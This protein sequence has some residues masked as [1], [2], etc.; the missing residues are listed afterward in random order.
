MEHGANMDGLTLEEVLS[1]LPVDD[2]VRNYW[3]QEPLYIRGTREKLSKLYSLDRFRASFHRPWP[4]SAHAKAVFDGR[5]GEGSDP[6]LFL[7]PKCLGEAFAAGATVCITWLD[8]VEPSLAAL[9]QDTKL[10]L[11]YAGDVHM[12]AYWSPHGAGFRPHFDA[13]IAT[14]LQ[15][16]GTKRW[17]YV[18]RPSIAWPRKNAIARNERIIYQAQHVDPDSWECDFD[19]DATE[20]KEVV[21]HPG[22]V[23]CLPAGTLHAAEAD[24][25]SF[26]LNLHFNPAPAGRFLGRMLDHALSSR[27]SWRCVPPLTGDA[28]VDAGP[29]GMSSNFLRERLTEAIQQLEAWREHPEKL[30]QHALADV[31]SHARWT[32]V[33]S[34]PEKNAISPRTVVAPS[35]RLIIASPRHSKTLVL[36]ERDTEV[37]LSDRDAEIAIRIIRSKGKPIEEIIDPVSIEDLETIEE[38]IVAGFFVAQTT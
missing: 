15:I 38:L 12:N 20:W 24:G 31:S 32:S 2:F 17:R 22:D 11:G 10:K 21:L 4:S 36:L 37:E 28:G 19:L 7:E 13:R 26:A 9:C 35:P 33:P 14:T 16:E 6:R 27:S 8:E 5:G 18:T 29:A 1:P 23:L 3:G 34:L 25:H 30:L